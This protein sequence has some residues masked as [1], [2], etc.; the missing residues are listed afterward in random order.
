[1]CG[2]NGSPWRCCAVLARRASARRAG[3]LNGAPRVPPFLGAR[4]VGGSWTRPGG[5]QPGSAVAGDVVSA[6]RPVRALAGPEGAGRCGRCHRTG[7][8]RANPPPHGAEPCQ[9]ATARGGTVPEGLARFRPVRRGWR[10]DMAGRA[11]RRGGATW[12]GGRATGWRYM[13]GRATGWRD[14]AGRRDVARPGRRGGAAQAR[15]STPGSTPRRAL[16]RVSRCSTTPSAT[17]PPARAHVPAS[18]SWVARTTQETRASTGSTVG[19]R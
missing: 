11:A 19:A 3:N 10:R 8:N 1:M 16:P 4:P 17:S 14:V 18:R 13:A 9:P 7:R 2:G 12:P 6:L 15:T 5:A